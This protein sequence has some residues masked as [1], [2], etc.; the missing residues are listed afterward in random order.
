LAAAETGGDISNWVARTFQAGIES[1]V[2]RNLRMIRENAEKSKQDSSSGPGPGPGADPGGVDSSLPD[3]KSAEMYRI[4]AAL[5]TEGSGANSVVDIMQVVVNR[6]ASGRYGKTFTDILAAGRS[7]NSCQFQGVW[8]RPGGPNAFR[9]IQTLEDAS[10]WSGQSQNALLGIIKNIQDPSLQANSAN[11]VGGALEFRAA[12]GYYKRFGLVAGE[13]GPDG[14]FYNSSWRGGPGDN[15]YLKQ[16][17]K[18]PTI[19]AAASFNLPAPQPAPKPKPGGGFFGGVAKLFG[20]GGGSE[21]AAP[22]GAVQKGSVVQ[23]LHGTPG[24]AGYEPYGHGGQK[25]AHDH[26]GFKS[27]SAALAAFTALEKSG[28]KPWQFEGFTRQGVRDAGGPGAHSASGGHYGPVGGKPTYNDMSDGTAFDIPW[29]TYGTGPIGPRDYA[30]SLGAAKIVGAAQGGGMVGERKKSD[31]LFDGSYKERGKGK[32]TRKPDLEKS[33]VPSNMPTNTAPGSIGSSGSGLGNM[34]GITNIGK[35]AFGGMDPLT[36][37][38]QWAK[39]FLELAKKVKSGQSG[40][41]EIQSYLK[42]NKL[43]SISKTAFDMPNLMDTTTPIKPSNLKGLESSKLGSISKTAFGM[44]NLM[45][46][47]TP[48]D[49]KGGEIT[50]K[51]GTKVKGAGVDT[52]LIAAQPGEVIINKPTVDTLGSEFFLALNRKY[53][54]SNANKIKPVEVYKAQGGGSIGKNIKTYNGV[55]QS[56]SYEQSS[57]TLLAIQP[58]MIPQPMPMGG[59]SG[60]GMDRITFAGSGSVNSYN[61]T[62]MRG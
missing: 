22:S 38:Q 25:N 42:G 51:S 21:S 26:F 46:T 15:Q 52:Q 18:D 8:K 55:D 5:S 62:K 60:G 56:A 36:P 11:H 37:M 9:K 50:S 27:R 29:S 43:G 24:R 44:P 13:M 48:T 1:K 30:K 23:W 6:K 49:L 20:G 16:A 41:E 32:D 57:G 10:R 53:G 2:E 28:Y 3:P 19:G 7:V 17:G 45:D 54:E 58:V 33:S 34:P 59:G 35:T 40:Y 12:P 14:R 39:N 4:A 31:I 61:P 47:T